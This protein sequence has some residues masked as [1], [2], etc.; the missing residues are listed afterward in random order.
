MEIEIVNHTNKSFSTVKVDHPGETCI[1]YD[2]SGYSSTTPGAM[3]RVR[4]EDRVEL[5][6]EL[7]EFIRTRLSEDDQLKLFIIYDRINNLF[8]DDVSFRKKGGGSAEKFERTLARLCCDIYNIVLWKDLLE[9]I[10]EK[11]KN[12][13]LLIPADI[14]YEHR[15]E[16]RLTP[17]YVDC[18]YLTP[19]YIQLMAM[20]LGYRFIIPVWGRYMPLKRY[21]DQSSMKEYHCFQLIMGSKFYKAPCFARLETYVRGGMDEKDDMGVILAGLSSEEIP[22]FLMAITSVRKLAVA[23]LSADDDRKHLIRMLYHYVKNKAINLGSTLGYNVRAKLPDSIDRDHEDNSSTLDVYKMREEIPVGDLAVIET[24]INKYMV[25]GIT[26]YGA[27]IDK[28]KV[29]E[30][31]AVIE[32][33]A[34]FRPAESQIILATWI[35]GVQVSGNAVPL[36][37]KKELMRVFAVAQTVLWG[38]GLNELAVLLTAK[39][40]PLDPGERLSRVKIRS[41][42]EDRMDKLREIYPHAL[43]VNEHRE[44]GTITNAGERSVERLAVM[45]RRNEWKADCPKELANSFENTGVVSIF[46]ASPD[47]RDQ[48]A[49]VLINLSKVY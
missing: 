28:S 44:Y 9:F 16:D 14:H 11:V 49:D 38:W 30:C 35:V 26:A 19:D 13:D 36:L 2:A 22:I 24:Y 31:L 23:S 21:D 42:S 34:V 47:A 1:I 32:E 48:L 4:G 18:T 20:I 41:I 33:N 12:G 7:N 5:F 3:K 8:N 43:N 29:A 17:R 15:T 40:V 27:E 46:E 45:F 25:D 10:E 37:A 6:G 39:E